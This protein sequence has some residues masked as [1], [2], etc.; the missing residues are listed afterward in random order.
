MIKRIKR[1]AFL[2]ASFFC[3][4]S[5]VV[6]Q[7]C[8]ATEEVSPPKKAKLYTV[9]GESVNLRDMPDENS[10]NVSK[11]YKG[12]T[13]EG[14]EELPGWIKISEGNYISA[15]YVEVSMN[16]NAPEQTINKEQPDVRFIYWLAGFSILGIVFIMKTGHSFGKSSGIAQG[17]SEGYKLGYAEGQFFGFKEG[18]QKAEGDCRVEFTPVCYEKKTDFLGFFESYDI[19][20]G[21]ITQIYMKGIPCQPSPFVLLDSSQETKVDRE[22]F[23]KLTEDLVKRLANSHPLTS[24][25]GAV[26]NILSPR[27]EKKND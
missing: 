20:K 10:D 24:L 1:Y 23:L 22:K 16:V 11:L 21:Y 26:S 9:V 4:Y 6:I 3:L 25:P 17:K 14:I 12:A 27:Y 8:H 2:I 15:D 7:D 13:I 18:M 5:T 19:Q